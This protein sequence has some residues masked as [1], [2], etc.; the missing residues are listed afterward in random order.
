MAKKIVFCADGTW[1]TPHG[2][3]VCVN[4]TNVRKLYLAL[5][6][7]PSQLRYYDSG[8]GTDGT[9]I[10][11][12]AGGT[13]GAGLFQK[14]RDGYEFLSYVYS[15]GDE[16]YLFGFSRGAY[17]ARSLAGM[18]ACFGVPTKNLDNMTVQRVFS[19]YRTVDPVQ[20]HQAKDSLALQYGLAEVTI[21]MVG[22]W[23]T[24]GSLGI[25]GLLFSLF[26][27]QQYGFLDTT[28]HPDVQKAFH[29]ICIDEQRAQFQPTLWSNPDG[30]YRAND[31]QL[32]QV[33]FAGVHCDV[34]GSYA[35]SQLSDIA[36]N[37][38]MAQAKQ[39]GLLFSADAIAGWFNLGDE[40]AL[41]VVHN[42]WEIVPWGLPK[43]RTIPSNAA[44]ART[45]A[46]RLMHDAT[47]RPCN[48]NLAPDGSLIGYS[49]AGN[50]PCALPSQ[51]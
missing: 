24:V 29:A 27:Q 41:G 39:N 44:I 38:M 20:R 28:L 10:D 3:G 30:S 49:L 2:V 13:I 34:G 5:L 36:L 37:W 8:V 23:D 35:Q 11:H 22:V 21:R 7:D 42:E 43:R 33:W 15:P 45:V 16:I 14:V 40:N 1:N 25:P 9:P 50:I 26:D 6:D 48:L 19:A 46:Y 18:L 31:D 12:L 4:D 17:T 47:Y 32:T 51:P